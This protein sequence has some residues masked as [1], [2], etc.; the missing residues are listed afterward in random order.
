MVIAD[1]IHS[2]SNANVA[3]AAVCCI[4]GEFAERVHA[5]ARKNGV[6]AGRFV[7]IVMRD[8]ARRA[9]RETLAGLNRKI[10]GAD[11]PVLRGLVHVL[12]PALEEDASFFDDEISVFGRG[13][14]CC[15]ARLEKFGATP[16][17]ATKLADGPWFS[18]SPS[19]SR[20]RC[21]VCAAPR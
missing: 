13:A 3:E 17:G 4:G 11:Q 6:N 8:F 15:A 18:A 14:L 19:V 12:E 9:S 20:E 5:A 2:C 21:F 10:A 1:M 7:S 16:L